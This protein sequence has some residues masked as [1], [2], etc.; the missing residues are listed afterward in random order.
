M[1]GDCSSTMQRSLY[2][3]GRPQELGQCGLREQ[4][5]LPRSK[6]SSN[7]TLSLASGGTGA[8]IKDIESTDS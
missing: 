4:F 1:Q 2:T 5:E 7:N 3:K 8:F 6:E